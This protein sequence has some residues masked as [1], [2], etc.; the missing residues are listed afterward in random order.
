M[1]CAENVVKNLAPLPR[2]KTLPAKYR[3]ERFGLVGSTAPENPFMR[4]ITGIYKPR[5]A[6]L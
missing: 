4:L 6:R 2:C 1:I 5:A 3:R